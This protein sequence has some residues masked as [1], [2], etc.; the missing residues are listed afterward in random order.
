[1]ARNFQITLF[2]FTMLFSMASET[3]LGQNLFSGDDFIETGT[4]FRIGD[5]CFQ[6]T[7]DY[8]WEGGGLWFKKP[9]DLSDP[10]VLEIEVLLGC[11][12]EGADGMVF[13]LH[14]ELTTGSRG[15]GMGFGRLYPSFGIEM[16][17][18]MNEHLA[19]PYYDH[20]AFMQHGS[21][22]HYYGL[23]DPV[24]L[25]STS[26][27]VEDC[28]LHT[29]KIDWNPASKTMKFYFDGSLR[30]RE[31]LDIVGELFDGNPQVYWG[32]TSA[33]GAKT[34]RH[35]VCIEHIE[36]TESF[37]L[38]SS[39]QRL[40]LDGG[41]YIIESLDFPS[42]SSKIPE[43]AKPELDKLAK[44]FKQYEKHTIILDGFT[45]SSGN[46]EANEK[47]SGLRAR[48]VAEYFQ[49]QGIPSS[50]LQYYGNGE[51]NPVAP[52]DTAEGRKRNR[53]VEIVFKVLKV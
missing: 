45:D 32:F 10:F 48:A 15:E 27:N 20:V 38:P 49:T 6:L 33:T 40:L 11:N 3:A 5:R 29:V 17:T 51:I 44:L 21:T 52:N 18:Y 14:P 34:N 47:I 1:M 9:I 2:F 16:D 39:V 28:A 31:T 13:I 26:N 36:Y 30:V 37:A 12:D 7:E 24:K 22:M 19:D 43:S 41:K 42:G 4:T 35:M 23:T 8:F 50:R 53:R 25:S 46:A